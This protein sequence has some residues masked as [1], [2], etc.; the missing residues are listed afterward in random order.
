VYRI[1]RKP[2]IVAHRG[3]S[4]VYPENTLC[5]IRGAITIGVDMVELDVRLSR[6]HVPVIFHSASLL[7]IT[8]CPRRVEELTAAELKTL[9]AGAWRGAAYCGERIPTL[10]EVLVLTRG[11]I[12]VNLDIKTPAAIE[13]VVALVQKHS[14]LDE[15][16]LSGCTWADARRVRRLEPSLH[17]LLNV[18]GYLRTLL[19]ILNTRLAFHLSRLQAYAAQPMGLNVSHHYGAERFIRDA[20]IHSLPVWT[21]TV[22]EPHRALQ[23]ARVGASSITSNWPDRIMAAL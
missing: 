20:A 14:M 8:A 22:D 16:V 5:A 11:K 1:V 18:D 19:R 12:P 17:V 21:W 15:V 2:Q 6:D 4:G 10:D 9:D 23:L 3:Y 7:S 13:A